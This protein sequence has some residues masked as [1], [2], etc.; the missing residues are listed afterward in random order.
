MKSELQAKLSGLVNEF[1]SDTSTS[2]EFIPGKTKVPVSGKVIGVG[3]IQ[4]M[5]EAAFDGWLTAGRFNASFEKKFSQF[6]G[7]KHVLTTNSGSSANLL[8]LSALTSPSLGDRK[9][10]AGDE[11]ITVAAGFPTTINPIIQNG[12][13]PVFVDIHIPTYNIDITK[14]EEAYSDKT[15]AIMVAHTLGNPFDIGAVRK[16]ADERGLWLIEDCCDALGSTF[17]NTKVG[18]FGD[19]A[20]FS[21]YPAHHITMGEGG[22]VVTNSDKLSKLI[23][24]FRD[25]GRD[26]FCKPGCDN[27]CKQRFSQQHGDLPDGYD[28]KYVYSHVGYNMKITDMQAACGVAQ[29]DRLEGFIQKRKQNFDYLTQCLSSLQ[30]KIILPEATPSSDPS[31]FGF[32]ITLKEEI[33]TSRTDLL[34]HLDSCKIGTRLLFAGNVLKQPYFK[35]LTHRVAGDLEKTDII[36]K[37]TFWVGIFPAITNEMLDYIS[38]QIGACL[39][40]DT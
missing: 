21:F 1:V 8:A 39:N 4:L 9:L 19:I 33:N 28:H 15:K 10:V 3:E 30:D 6:L 27:T 20:T 31:W 40:G 17:N 13:V 18:T 11:V 24:S 35:N 5:A 26:C 14:L 29:M 32:P 37:S 34:V 7:A 22:A 12:L 38:I 2:S 16:F 36:L 25:W 23:E